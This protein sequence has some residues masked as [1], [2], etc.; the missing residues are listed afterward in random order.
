M[1]VVGG[2]GEKANVTGKDLAAA[3]AP[4]RG[5]APVLNKE[6]IDIKERYRK[7]QGKSVFEAD[8]AQ[9]PEDLMVNFDEMR[10]VLDSERKRVDAETDVKKK[11]VLQKR[12]DRLELRYNIYD[13]LLNNEGL[14]AM[15][16]REQRELIATMALLP[17]FAEAASVAIGGRLSTEQ[18]M[19]V[20][21]GKGGVAVTPDEKKALSE[22]I[23][24]MANDD[25]FKNRV[26]KNLSAL[27][28]S[29][30]DTVKSQE[31]SD[32]RDT[33]KDEAAKKA[34]QVSQKATIDAFEGRPT[35]E[36]ERIN[37][38]GKSTDRYLAII[39]E[40]NKP[41][42]LTL[43]EISAKEAELLTLVSS[44]TSAHAAAAAS[45]AGGAGEYARLTQ[46][47]NELS[48]IRALKGIYTV[49]TAT[50]DFQNY[51]KVADTRLKKA[52]IDGELKVIDV[53]KA[54]IAKLD[55]ER[56][57]YADKYK[58]QMEVALSEEMKRYWNDV[59]LTNASKAA[60]A[61]AAI[62]GEE[63]QKAKDIAEKRV[64]ISKDM[65]DRFT[66]L[67]FWRYEGGE[68][69]GLDDKA[70][71][72]FVKKDML[73]RSPKQL[74][75]DILDR[76]IR[77]RGQMPYS[78]GKEIDTLLKQMGVGEGTPPATTREVLNSIDASNYQT[79]A[80]EKIPD[81]LGYARARGYYFDRMKFKPGQ[82]E[83]L[84]RAYP[85]EF[86]E[87]AAAAKTK[88]ADQAARLMGGDLKD[89]MDGGALNWKKVR[90]ALAGKDWTEGTKK[91][92]KYLAY[93]GAGYALGGGLIWDQA[94]TYLGLGKVLNT[95]KNVGSI[96]LGVAGAVSR[97]GDWTLGPVSEAIVKGLDG[98]TATI[99]NGVT[100]VP[101]KGP[102]IPIR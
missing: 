100:T 12:Y 64:K 10:R 31:L 88:Y 85:A 93:A 69:K 47:Q 8:I 6:I 48:A 83:F 65:L 97:A 89:F 71:K 82:A 39:S 62:K 43:P 81:M 70:L 87:K 84:Q 34:L 86:F 20:L 99:M 38:V 53:N 55:G 61:R 1:A 67:S 32:L 52:I 42:S 50:S 98:T 17:G 13:K 18:M 26:S 59:S 30:D 3:L 66:E 101:A 40:S 60:E 94:G 72:Q 44:A 23:I 76:I 15:D 24:L 75:R 56:S 68:S 45:N 91:L 9:N 25:R 41:S 28:L 16:N 78:Y 80:E 57:K 19:K 79:W 36:I 11:D 96:P 58:R 2:E 63:E 21:S 49:G 51:E 37:K 102:F 7:D 54:K 4:E 35:V 46:L 73:S 22:I 5:R 74:S 27:S 33:I 92:M 29:E 77:N 90:E 95:L 14:S